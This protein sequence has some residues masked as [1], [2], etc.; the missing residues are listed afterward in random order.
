MRDDHLL[1]GM[2]DFHESVEFLRRQHHLSR[3]ST[4][5]HA[6]I[7]AS[8]LNQ[9]IQNRT[10]PGPVVFDKLV[11]SLDLD[12]SRRRHLEEL[13][14]PSADLPPAEELRR[15]LTNLGVRTHLDQLDHREI[16]GVYF[17]PLL[18]VLHGNQILHRV[19]P[20]LADADH[21]IMKWML[22]A[23]A[24]DSIINWD[25]ELRFTI[26]ILRTAL[27][28]Y[29][30]LPRARL[31]FQD[32]STHPAFRNAWRAT[33]MRVTY[34]WSRPAPLRLRMPGTEQ[35]VGLSIEIDEYGPDSDILIAHGLY[36]T[37]AI[38]C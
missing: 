7:S 2:P 12:A 36:N 4:A 37:S 29:R 8:Y 9:L 25:N 33:P 23:A 11:S 6:G 17:D 22:S 35:P 30:D 26:S 19:M 16:M 21:N 27:G 1:D 5:H 24:R 20:G 18:N 31:L 13:W 34:Y 28:R 38:A 10:N 32:L 14:Q 15:R 3:E